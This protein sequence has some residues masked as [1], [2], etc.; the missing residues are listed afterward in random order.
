MHF[1]VLNAFFTRCWGIN[2]TIKNVLK[3]KQRRREALRGSLQ[4]LRHKKKNVVT[5]VPPYSICC[6]TIWQSLTLKH[7][8]CFQTELL[9]DH[10]MAHF[11]PAL[12]ASVHQSGG[13][14]IS[15]PE[16]KTGF[17]NW[18]QESSARFRAE[19][20]WA[21]ASE[22]FYNGSC[23]SLSLCQPQPFCHNCRLLKLCMV[24]KR[25]FWV[26]VS[27]QG[28]NKTQWSWLGMHPAHRIKE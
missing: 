3:S 14:S 17:R 24:L 4:C 2:L 16:L 15:T 5:H 6:L 20:C 9:P 10:C 26:D 27:I 19:M 7:M 21:S 1:M 25:L 12:Y 18:I 13:T 23:H 8:V 28:H 11:P 22:V